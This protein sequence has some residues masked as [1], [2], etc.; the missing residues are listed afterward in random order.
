MTLFAG[1]PGVIIGRK[2][3]EV[4]RLRARLEEIVKQKVDI[5][6][7]EIHHPEM[8]AQLVAEGIAEQLGKRA[9]FKRTVRKAAETTLDAGAK[10]VRIRI[11][12]RLGGAEDVAARDD[13][14]RLD[15]AAHAARED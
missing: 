1:R 6:I 7:V 11:A 2:G 14:P 10:G 13:Q 3:S 5:N 15:S 8:D 4:D 12:G 9:S